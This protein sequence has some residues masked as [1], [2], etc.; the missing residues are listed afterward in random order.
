LAVGLNGDL[1]GKPVA[2]FR[3]LPVFGDN[4][5]GGMALS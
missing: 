3:T 2:F 1:L 4:L 5:H